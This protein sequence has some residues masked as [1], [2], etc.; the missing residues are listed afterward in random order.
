M[1]SLSSTT[2]ARVV[3]EP[4]DHAG[5][6]RLCRLYWRPVHWQLATRRIDRDQNALEL[7]EAFFAWLFEA[8]PAACPA[9]TQSLRRF[10]GAAIEHFV[11]SERPAATGVAGD[12]GEHF[13]DHDSIGGA[14]L[15]APSWSP[16]ADFDEL[17]AAALLED[18]A[19]ELSAQLEETGAAG[20]RLAFEAWFLGHQR[21]DA[22]GLAAELGLSSAALKSTLEGNRRVLRSLLRARLADTL[23]SPSELEPEFDKLFG[24]RA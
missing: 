20:E 15:V 4:G 13:L 12:R 23:V 22:D 1:E 16:D 2:W 11:A 5:L 17:F 18:T 21:P 8:G 9:E 7:T 24:P 3:T 14:D 19:A 6:A 10:L